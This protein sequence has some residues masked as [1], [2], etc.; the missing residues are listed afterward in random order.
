[1]CKNLDLLG[2]ELIAID[3][4]KFRAVNSKKR[5]FNEAKLRRALKEIEE[6]VEQYLT[7]L[8]DNYKVEACIASPLSAED[9]KEKIKILKTERINIR[10]H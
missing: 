4:S 5:N 6:K 8:E 9:I 2:G 1:M 10:D 3:S 7:E